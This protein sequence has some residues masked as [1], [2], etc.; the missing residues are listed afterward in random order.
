MLVL[1]LRFRLVC[2]MF[3][4]T[5]IDGRLGAILFA[6]RISEKPPAAP[7][8]KMNSVV[9]DKPKFRGSKPEEAIQ[10]ADMACGATGAYLDGDPVWYEI[11]APVKGN[12]PSV[13]RLACYLA[14]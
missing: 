12:R 13:C 1:R 4:H 11:K 3:A 5:D 2:C 8:A 7:V 14:V 9:V 10:L 6:F